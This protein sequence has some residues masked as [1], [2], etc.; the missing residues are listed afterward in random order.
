M[1]RQLVLLVVTV[2]IGFSLAQSDPHHPEQTPA[3]TPSTQ[4]KLLPPL[5]T[6]GGAINPGQPGINQGQSGMMGGQ[7]SP[8]NMMQMMQGMMNQMGMGLTG[9]GLGV[10]EGAPFEQA[11][12]SMMIPHHRTAVAMARD[13]LNK[14]QD[15]QIRGWASAIIRDQEREIS[16]MRT[17]LSTLGGTNLA[18]Q[19]AMTQS[20]MGQ[21]SSTGMGQNSSTANT[22]QSGSDSMMQP[23]QTPASPERVFLEAMIPH[24]LQAIQMA[25]LALQKA[26]NPVIVKLASEIVVAQAQEVYQMR[27]KLASLR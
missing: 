11:F 15:E 17:L 21:N 10:L 26:Q 24:H 2:L 6:P 9:Q 20:G 22:A 13:I 8:M 12:L 1:K 14:T 5:P 3:P 4:P 19:R 7:Q 25:T 23:S 16:Q 27:L 18:A